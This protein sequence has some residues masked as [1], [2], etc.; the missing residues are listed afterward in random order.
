MTDEPTYGQRFLDSWKRYSGVL[1]AFDYATIQQLKA[2]DREAFIG[3]L[4]KRSSMLPYA[5]IQ[6]FRDCEPEEAARVLFTQ[7]QAQNQ[8]AVLAV[9]IAVS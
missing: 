2:A 8:A 6:L 4:R 7:A 1:G 3:I 9:L 5:T